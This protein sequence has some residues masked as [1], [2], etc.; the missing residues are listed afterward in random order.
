MAELLHDVRDIDNRS[1][2]QIIGFLEARVEALANRVKDW[3]SALASRRF[4]LITQKH[5][6]GLTMEETAVLAALDEIVAACIPKPL[7]VSLPQ[8]PEEQA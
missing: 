4:A 3:E 2:E 1:P 6:G 8:L 5:N 7:L